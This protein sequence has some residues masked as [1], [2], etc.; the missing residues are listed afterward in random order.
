MIDTQ[1]QASFEW[2]EMSLIFLIGS[3]LLLLFFFL[4]FFISQ[5][6]ITDEVTVCTHKRFLSSKL[7]QVIFF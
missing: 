3:F 2:V 6:K 4:P 1:K 7:A 5:N